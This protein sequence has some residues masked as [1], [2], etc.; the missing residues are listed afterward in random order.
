[1]PRKPKPVTPSPA[2]IETPPPMGHNKPPAEAKIALA[3]VVNGANE[4][5]KNHP[6][7]TT[8]AE[9]AAGATYVSQVKEALRMAEAERDGRVRP[10]NDEVKEING[11][12][13]G[14]KADAKTVVEAAN[15]RLTAFARAEEAKR[16]AEV[17]RLEAEA[18]ARRQ[19]VIEAERK[20]AEARE[21]AEMG[22][23]GVD[24]LAATRE[25]D[26]AFKDYQR[27]ER[28]TRVAAK[29]SRL[30]VDTG[31]ARAASMREIETLTMGS[32]KELWPALNEDERQIVKDAAVTAARACRK[33]TG[34]LPPGII[35]NVE[36]SFR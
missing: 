28:Q 1:M 16:L 31:G 15:A 17:R 34:E 29:D 26:Q 7:V 4:W 35:R 11:E 10:L 18:E 9:A 19:A 24:T 8:Q 5:L 3:G 6:A 22:E 2:E 25:A 27:T 33:R 23:V 12:Y 32:L 13:A 30:R 14:P 36:R 21:N 20:E